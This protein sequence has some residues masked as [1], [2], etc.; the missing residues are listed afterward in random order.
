M[1]DEIVSKL[2]VVPKTDS[3]DFPLTSRER[4]LV[5]NFRAMK[6]TAQEMLLDL[7]DQ[8]KRTLPAAPVKL[9][10]LRSGK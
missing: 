7:S 4:R 10:L 8:Y 5:R 1:L 3:E 2:G 6:S 9:Q